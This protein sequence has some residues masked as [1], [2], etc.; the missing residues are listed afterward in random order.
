MKQDCSKVP[1]SEI[2]TMYIWLFTS[3]ALHFLTHHNGFIYF[4]FLFHFAPDSSQ[5][6]VR[7]WLH[8]TVS[9][10]RSWLSADQE[11]PNFV[12]RNPKVLCRVQRSPPLDPMLTFRVQI[13]CPISVEVRGPVKRFLTAVFFRWEVVNAPPNPPAGGPRLLCCPRLLV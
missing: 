9:I 11:I 4:F 3:S 13:S 8:G 6:V 7:D 2:C 5:I 12:F 1:V 10:L